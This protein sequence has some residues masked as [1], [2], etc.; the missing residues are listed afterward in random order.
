[1]CWAVLTFQFGYAHA[2]AHELG[3]ET[4][5][6]NF[7]NILSVQKAVRTSPKALADS[8]GGGANFVHLFRSV[9]RPM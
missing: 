1:M 8:A 6:D 5:N 3:F 9:Y 7:Y 4:G 2:C